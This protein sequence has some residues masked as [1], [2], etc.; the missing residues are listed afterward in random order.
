MPMSVRLAPVLSCSQL[1]GLDVGVVPLDY[2]QAWPALTTGWALALAVHG[3][4]HLK[5]Q[6]GLSHV[7]R[8][9]QQVGMM[10][11]SLFKPALN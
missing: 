5:S 11:A 2:A 8:P 1:Q 10:K 3:L 9:G 7:G 6:R 4:G